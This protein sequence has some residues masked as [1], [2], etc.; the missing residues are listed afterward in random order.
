MQ[1]IPAQA[2][3]RLDEQMYFGRRVSAVIG[4]RVRVPA[5]RAVVI[6]LGWVTG[7]DGPWALTALY[8]HRVLWGLY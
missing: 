5:V 8:G 1:G 7:V 2:D 3:D 6:R 4:H